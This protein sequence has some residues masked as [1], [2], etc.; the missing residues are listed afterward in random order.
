MSKN[1][2]VATGYTLQFRSLAFDRVQTL[3]AQTHKG[4][5]ILYLLISQVELHGITNT[6]P[7][8]PDRFPQGRAFSRK[9]ELRWKTSERAG[10]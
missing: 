1:E 2:P 9:A 3:V 4:D 10:S 7:D 8:C 5:E 6:M